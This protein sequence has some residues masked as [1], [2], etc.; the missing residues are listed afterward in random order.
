MKTTV[1]YRYVC[2][3]RDRHGNVRYYFRRKGQRKIRLR[4]EPGTREFQAAYEAAGRQAATASRPAAI[5][6]PKAGSFRSLCVS[7]FASTDFGQLDRST[8][9]VRRRILESMCQEPIAPGGAQ[10]F[11]DFPLARFGRKAVRIL[12]DRKADLPW[13]ANGR[14]KAIRRLFKW[15]LDEDVA[16]IAANPA[17]D[18]SYLKGR[19][20]G[21]HSWTPEEVE[22][23]ETRHPVGSKA[24]L[25]LALLLYTGQRRSDVILFG[26]EHVRDGWLRFTQ[27]KN[28][29][30]KPITLALPILPV[31][32]Q[33]LDATPL[34]AETFLVT[35]YGKPF[36]GNGFGNKMRQWCD[37]AGLPLCTAH[38][39][40]KAGAAIAAENGATP[41]QLMSIFGWLTLAEAERYTRAAE[42]KRIVADA[43]RLLERREARNVPPDSA[44]VSHPLI[45]N[46]HSGVWRHVG[47]SNP[48]CSRERRAS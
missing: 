42:Q 48:C 34:G 23:F 25:A 43:I 24:R 45:Q 6:R 28:R 17:R 11:A 7:Y 2:Q 3:D 14:L 36:T 20:G 35:D 29:N 37:E 30:R 41:H 8:Q 16:G 4:A 31:L 21:H 39:L 22:R 9:V 27:Q 10:T 5:A 13:A 33:V 12:R 40:R 47:D 26:A 32:L 46:E 1:H 15:A 38:G 44:D 18:V 19:Q